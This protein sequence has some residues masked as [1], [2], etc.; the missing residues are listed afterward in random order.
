MIMK[1]IKTQLP[2]IL[3]FIIANNLFAINPIN[4]NFHTLTTSDGLADN[5][6]YCIYKDKKRLHVV[7]HQ[8]RPKQV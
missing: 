8:Q 3:I 7:W 1:V 5:T 2:L 6:I 4:T